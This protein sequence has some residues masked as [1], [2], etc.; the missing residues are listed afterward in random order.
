MGPRTTR[1]QEEVLPLLRELGIGLAACSPPGHGFL[2]G[3]IRSESDFGPDDPG[4]RR[5]PTVCL[6]P[7]AGITTRRSCG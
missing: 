1:D 3:A 5:S 2:T 7:R 4:N 6:R